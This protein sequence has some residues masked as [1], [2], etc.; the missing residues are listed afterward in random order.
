M[1]SKWGP[2]IGVRESDGKSEMDGVFDANLLLL[3]KL[4]SLLTLT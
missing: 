2:E 1:V 4:P 3:V